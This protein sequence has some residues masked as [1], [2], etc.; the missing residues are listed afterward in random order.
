MKLILAFLVAWG[1]A[2][3]GAVIGSILGHAA[4]N[5]GLFAGAVVGGIVGVWAA[6]AVLT[7]FGWLRREHRRGAFVGGFI[8]FAVAAPLAVT[9]LH[10]PLVPVLSCALAGVGVLIGVRAARLAGSGQVWSGE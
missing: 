3:L 5:P 1:C 9:H 2:G 4:G 7:T 6:V 8:G 10:T